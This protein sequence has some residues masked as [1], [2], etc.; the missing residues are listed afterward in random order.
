MAMLPELAAS[1]AANAIS[2]TAAYASLSAS[3]QLFGRTLI[4][5][6][7]P[8]EIALTFDDGPN[9]PYTGQLLEVLAR[10]E[11]RATFFMIG[12]F[13]RQRPDVVRAVQSAGHLIGNHTMTH[14][15]LV[16]ERPS[17]VRR[18]LSDCNSA[19]EDVLGEKV[20]YFRPPHGA[21][22][23]DVLRTA[24][25][26]GLAPVMWNVFG[27]DWK[28]QNDAARIQSYVEKGLQRNRRDGRGSNITLHD[29]GQAGFGQDR[30]ATVGAVRS[31]L[32]NM[33]PS[34]HFIAVNQLQIR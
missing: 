7:D 12:R 34:T 28:P 32:S 2:G 4:A 23:P 31:L 13:A 18:E 27:Y 24:Q 5:G 30:S 9:D 3:S 17:S 14:P 15:W 16:L 6:P 29:G 1:A 10:R 11:V 33:D 25:E 20:R 21:R 8:D 22:R 26:L 19:L